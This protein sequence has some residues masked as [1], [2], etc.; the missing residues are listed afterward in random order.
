MK[1]FDRTVIFYFTGTGNT[2]LMAEEI[3][4]EM[5]RR[6]VE[7]NLEAIEQAS[8]QLDISRYGIV[9]L[10]FPI[11]AW[12]F[13]SNVRRFL[14]K[15]PKVNGKKAFIFSTMQDESLGSEALAGRY[16]KRLGYNVI[17]ARPFITANNE[18]IYFGPEDARD[19][20]TISKIER[21]KARAPRFV[22]EILSGRGEIEHNTPL[23]ISLSQVSG[24]AFDLLDGYLASRNLRITPDCT[25]CGLC[26]K[27][28]PEANIYGSL[29]WP[30]FRNRC[31]M[32]ERCVSF[33]PQKAIIHP[34][35]R[36]KH[37][38][39][40]YRAPGYRP[41]VL[42]KPTRWVFEGERTPEHELAP[43]YVSDK[44]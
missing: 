26:E 19:P 3:A 29:T 35:H 38:D 39:I 34:L 36:A 15:F 40:R 42:R 10:G 33:C 18:T 16:L 27:I 25:S 4:R 31:L 37:T 41:P 7:T 30:Q 22:E 1:D 43:E 14:R 23:Y 13:P 32:C 28:C 6:G 12:C 17:A 21:M 11:Y 24:M 2:W 9:G 8:A 5:E 44:D 20:S